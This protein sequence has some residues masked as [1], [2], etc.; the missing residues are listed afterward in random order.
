VVKIY[1]DGGHGGRD[2]GAVGNGINEKDI[3]L[4]LVK[5]IEEIL[6]KNYQDVEI[7]QTRTTDV[8]LSLSQRTDKA[9]KW[10]ADYFISC[11]VNSSTSASANGFGSHIYI[12]TDS[13]TKAFQNVMHEEI[14]RKIKPFGVTD[15]GK[16]QNDFHVLRESHMTAILTE[17]L[18]ISNKADSDKLKRADY[19]QATAEGH[20]IGLEKFIG[21]KKSQQPPESTTD[22]LYKVQVGSFTEKK[23]AEELSLQLKKDGYKPFI[24]EA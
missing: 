19:I 1:L 10:G 13:K 9:N 11:H 15:R 16:K 22:T 2:P 8:F 23:N 14:M 18:F 7:M 24:T 3:N 12:K 5:K 21:L 20:V 17:N 6:K 4:Q